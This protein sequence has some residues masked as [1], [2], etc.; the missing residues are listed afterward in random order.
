[1]ET[2]NISLGN[3]SIPLPSVNNWIVILQRF[4]GSLDFNETWVNYRNGFGNT[5]LG[6]FWLGNEKIYLLT[7]KTGLIYRL[8]LEVF[9]DRSFAFNLQATKGRGGT[10]PTTVFSIS[11]FLHLD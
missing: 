9:V 7:N 10:H 3:G 6:E 8:R 2:A 5:G 4:N 1:M 11:H